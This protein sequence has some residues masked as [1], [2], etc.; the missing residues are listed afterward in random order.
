MPTE[1]P[2]NSL[3]QTTKGVVVKATPTAVNAVRGQI[4]DQVQAMRHGPLA[5]ERVV[6]CYYLTDPVV[7]YLLQLYLDALTKAGVVD[8]SHEAETLAPWPT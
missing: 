5:V 4:Q 7:Q 3:L 2:G 6:N 1:F 8:N